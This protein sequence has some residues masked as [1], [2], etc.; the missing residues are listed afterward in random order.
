LKSVYGRE[1][2]FIPIQNAPTTY[3]KITGIVLH[4]SKA[5]YINSLILNQTVLVPQYGIEP[6]DGLALK[7]YQSAMP[8]YKIVGVDCRQYAHLYGAV[9]CL[10]HEIYAANPIYVK[11]KWYQGIVDNKPDGYPVQVTAKS[12]DGIRQATLHWRTG[13]K[14]RFT[15]Q[16]MVEK[17]TDLF[18]TLIPKVNSGTAIEYFIEIENNNGKLLQKPPFAPLNAY[19]FTI[20]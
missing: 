18:E 16:P 5:T 2:K 7:T 14:D 20:Q 9:H 4:T 12:A 10:T 8:G 11:H 13:K 6:F 3:D 15:L 19:Q 1:I 17:Q